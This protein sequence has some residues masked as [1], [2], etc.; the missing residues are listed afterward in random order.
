MRGGIGHLVQRN[1]P[2]PRRGGAGTVA[3]A[4]ERVAGLVVAGVELSVN[5]TA[6]LRHLGRGLGLPPRL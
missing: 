3:R 1:Q 6:V 2:E 4:G 5:D